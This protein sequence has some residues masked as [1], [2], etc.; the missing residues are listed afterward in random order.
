MSAK[1]ILPSISIISPVYKSEDLIKELVNRIEK[2]IKLITINYEIILVEDCGGDNSW[3]VIQNLCAEN[4]NVIGI[5]LSK[6]FGQQYAIQA[7][8]DKCKNDYIVVLDCDLQD[9]P[10]AIPLLLEKCIEG[11]FDIVVASRTNRQ[12]GRLKK[13]LSKIFNSLMSYLTDSYQDEEV[14][15]FFLITKKV[16]ISLQTIHDYRRYY[17]LLLQWVGFRYTK[18]NVL[19]SLRGDNKY[20]SYSIKRRINLAID[21]I[22]T[23]SD[24]PLRMTVKLGVYVCVCAIIATIIL[25]LTYLSGKIAVPG[26]TSLS[27]LVSFFSG[28]II[29]ILGMIGM[30][31]G[32]TFETV[33]GRPTYIINEI[34]NG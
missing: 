18:V 22:L 24:K 14:A 26:W 19:H 31:L 17:P 10:E 9:P 8:L 7:G 33:K 13:L 34:K 27:I 6:N 3:K 5:R 1:S 21:T 4:H 32:K 11:N 28:V 25:F 12:D 15:N 16:L 2:S 29:T 23:F 30:Y 20:S